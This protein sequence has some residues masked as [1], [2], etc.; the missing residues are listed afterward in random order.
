MKT[1]VQ[2][3]QALLS[4][5]APISLDALVK[6]TGVDRLK[7][8]SNLTRFNKVGVVKRI[9]KGLSVTYTIADKTAAENLVAGKRAHSKAEKPTK[10]AYKK[11]SVK[12]SKKKTR[13]TQKRAAVPPPVETVFSFFVDEES[14]VQVARTDGEGDATILPRADALRLRDFLIRVS[15][16]LE[17]AS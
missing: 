17:A 6:K 15:P 3:L 14:D 5:S 9:G 4:E 1:S 10:R 13:K 12:R 8:I 2:I 11:R 7:L 16:M